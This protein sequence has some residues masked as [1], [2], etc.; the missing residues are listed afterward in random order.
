[1]GPSSATSSLLFFCA[2][3]VSLVLLLWLS[4]S[5]A[6]GGNYRHVPTNLP[7]P[8]CGAAAFATHAALTLAA[9]FVE[10]E[11]ME[12]G[13]AGLLLTAGC[14]SL[15]FIG[16]ALMANG[17]MSG[18]P[19]LQA[20]G[21]CPSLLARGFCCTA[22]LM[23]LCGVGRKSPW[24]LSQCVMVNWSLLLLPGT[25][26]AYAAPGSA[27]LLHFKSI[28][29]LLWSSFA[30]YSLSRDL[31]AARNIS[32]HYKQ[33]LAR[34]TSIPI[35]F[36]A[37]AIACLGASRI[38]SVPDAT[39]DLLDG[40]AEVAYCLILLCV[41][42]SAVVVAAEE[43]KYCTIQDES[44]RHR[45][46]LAAMRNMIRTPLDGIHALAKRNL[47]QCDHQDWE[48]ALVVIRDTSKL[49]VRRVL[50]SAYLQRLNL[51]M[52]FSTVSIREIIEEAVML[53]RP[54]LQQNAKLIVPGSDDPPIIMEG[55]FDRLVQ[56]L[57]GLLR[58]AVKYTFNGFISVSSRIDPKGN[59]RLEI[60]DTGESLLSFELPLWNE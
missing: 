8:W 16:H 46:A 39:L 28:P 23:V 59:L 1:M 57:H 38:G 2:Y 5:S 15:G 20:T 22:M 26:G 19:L 58:I 27:F 49:L 41:A 13:R 21:S 37:A 36:S 40:L 53:A 30:A 12:K 44:L 4:S 54:L 24:S 52:R 3:G 6:D 14:S 35:A 51:D 33:C 7:L 48:D 31:A 45:I 43:E 56:M 34:S 29:W 50:D 42:Q 32:N 47:S 55:D 18:V 9:A 11:P 60:K 17:V 10:G 25:L